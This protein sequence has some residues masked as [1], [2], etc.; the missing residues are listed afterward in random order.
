MTAA[1]SMH[2]LKSRSGNFRGPPG[3]PGKLYLVH[4]FSIQS[5]AARA[6]RQIS[7]LLSLQLT[8]SITFLSLFPDLFYDIYT[9]RRKP[10][11]G[12]ASQSNAD[13]FPWT[14][15]SSYKFSSSYVRQPP[16][17]N[18]AKDSSWLRRS[19]LNNVVASA[20]EKIGR[21]NKKWVLGFA[22]DKTVDGEK[23]YWYLG[24]VVPC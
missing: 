2:L 8:T 20:F 18:E 23:K 7:F 21:M 22:L 1:S 4:G 14:I 24:P 15:R 3:T 19:S 11:Y 17:N 12:Q 6:P 13:W 9:Y 10:S 16:E 5:A